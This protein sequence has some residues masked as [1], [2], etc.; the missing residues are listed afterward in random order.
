MKSF[1]KFRD[2]VSSVLE[3]AEETFD[4]IN[5][6][7]GDDAERNKGREGKPYLTEA[8]R[9]L[10]NKIVIKCV[11]RGSS[12]TLILWD[13][14]METLHISGYDTTAGMVSVDF[15]KSLLKNF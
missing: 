4:V 2:V 15:E 3:S 13:K 14:R 1:K 10:P 8:G 11:S 6:S 5:E 7:L 9:E 12:S